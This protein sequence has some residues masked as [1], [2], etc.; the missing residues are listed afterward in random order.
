VGV[1]G[2]LRTHFRKKGN[3]VGGKRRGGGSWISVAIIQKW[4]RKFD[5]GGN[6]GGFRSFLR[7]RLKVSFLGTQRQGA[8]RR[9]LSKKKKKGSMERQGFGRV[10][11]KFRIG[12]GMPLGGKERGEAIEPV[13]WSSKGFGPCQRRRK[14]L[15]G[16]VNEW[17]ELTPSQEK[18]PEIT[19]TTITSTTGEAPGVKKS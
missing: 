18:E 8:H 6:K 16:T 14:H 13:A 15:E 10:Q 12:K 5:Q 11:K 1:G 3:G 2:P 17:K 4:G 9:G 7:G 19:K